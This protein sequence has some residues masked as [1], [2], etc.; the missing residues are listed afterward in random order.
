VWSRCYLFNTEQ[1]PLLLVDQQGKI[2]GHYFNTREDVDR[3]LTEATI[4]L[5]KY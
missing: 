3:L 2:R 4:I 1:K 5:K